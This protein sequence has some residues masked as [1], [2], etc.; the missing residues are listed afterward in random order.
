MT[1]SEATASGYTL[2]I[3][4]DGQIFQIRKTWPRRQW[5]ERQANK[6]NRRY[7]PRFNAW[8]RP[9]LPGDPYPL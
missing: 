3:M 8:V 7:G 4:R 5:A 6:L 9:A 2:V 1:T